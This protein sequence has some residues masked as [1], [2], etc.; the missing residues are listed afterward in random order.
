MT[1]FFLNILFIYLFIY[2]F[3]VHWVFIAAHRFS[4]VATSWAER[5]ADLFVAVCRL[6]IAVASLVA[7]HRL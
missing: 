4:L 6:L 2:L 5:G 7:E 3:L 1:T